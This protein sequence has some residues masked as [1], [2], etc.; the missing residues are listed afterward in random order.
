MNEEFDY[1]VND[2]RIYYGLL[3]R[4]G[5][6]GPYQ[7]NFMTVIYLISLLSASTF[8]V[9]PFLFYQDV[10]TCEGYEGD[11]HKMVCSLP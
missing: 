6:E 10:Y 2:E 1:E 11:C 9:V 3:K 4:V 5:L 8:F 7:R